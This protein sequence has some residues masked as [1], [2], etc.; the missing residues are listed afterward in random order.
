MTDSAKIALQILL[1]VR[2]FGED[3]R[4][5]CL[6]VDPHTLT[7]YKLLMDK[8]TEAQKAIGT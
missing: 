7:H 6:G 2:A 1:D 3:I 4:N 5:V 8:V